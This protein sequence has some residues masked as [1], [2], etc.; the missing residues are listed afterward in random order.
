MPLLEIACFNPESALVAQAARADRIELCKDRHL[1][2]TTPLLSDFQKLKKD[3]QIPVNVM[4]RT[5]GGDF[6]YD[7]EELRQMEKEL[8]MFL[9]AGADGFVFGILDEGRVDVERCRR[10]V[11]KAKGRPCTFH[12][13]FDEIPEGDML[14]QLEVLVECGFRSVLTSGG[15]KSAVEGSR[16]LRRL[17]E[18]AQGRI[19]VIIGGG[20]RSTNL[21]VLKNNTGAGTFHSSAIVTGGELA[22]KEEIEALKNLMK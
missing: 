14:E 21:Q 9:E 7:D 12:R 10:L 8:E 22:S 15:K 5:R 11:E 1:G 6:V 18:P 16:V 4:I 2:G 17:I 13:A 20:I 19:D 3:I